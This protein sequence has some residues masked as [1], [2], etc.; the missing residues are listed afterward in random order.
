MSGLAGGFSVAAI[1]PLE[2]GLRNEFPGFPPIAKNAM[3]GALGFTP[4][5][6]HGWM[7]RFVNKISKLATASR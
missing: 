5:E 4:D 1:V 2:G 6:H 3:D 7:R